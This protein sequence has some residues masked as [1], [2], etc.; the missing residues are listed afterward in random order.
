MSIGALALAMG[1]GPAVVFL[2]AGVGVR[3]AVLVAALTTVLTLPDAIAVALVSR[4]LVVLGDA[5]WGCSPS[6][7]RDGSP[8]G[9]RAAP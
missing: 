6:W 4:A 8:R 7:R 9:T 3:E 5:R 2:P 1:L